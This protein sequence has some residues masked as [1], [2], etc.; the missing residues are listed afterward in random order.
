MEAYRSMQQRKFVEFVS[1]SRQVADY[2]QL[3]PLSTL[4]VL[5]DVFWVGDPQPDDAHEYAYTV[6]EELAFADADVG[7]VG[8]VFVPEL[9]VQL[10]EEV[11]LVLPHSII[12]IKNGVERSE[13]LYKD[14]VRH[15]LAH[16]AHSGTTEVAK[17]QICNSF[18]RPLSDFNNQDL[19]WGKRV[20]EASCETFKDLFWDKTGPKYA[21]NRTQLRLLPEWRSAWLDAV[22]PSRFFS[23]Q[24]NNPSNGGISAGLQEWR[25][26]PGRELVSPPYDLPL[27]KASNYKT[28]LLFADLPPGTHAFVWFQ[29]NRGGSY[30]K[31]W[32]GTFENSPFMDGPYA[33][34]P[35]VGA[36]EFDDDDNPWDP[37]PIWA[38]ADLSISANG[39]MNVTLGEGAIV[40]QEIDV[41][42]IWQESG[43]GLLHSNHQ[44]E[45]AEAVAPFLQIEV[46]VHDEDGNACLLLETYETDDDETPPMVD[47][48]TWRVDNVAGSDDD[49]FTSSQS[50]PNGF[51]I[52]EWNRDTVLGSVAHL[53]HVEAVEITDVDGNGI[54]KYRWLAGGEF[55]LEIHMSVAITAYYPYGYNNPDEDPNFIADPEGLQT[56]QGANLG[57]AKA[58]G[59]IGMPPV[60]AQGKMAAEIAPPGNRPRKPA[61]GAPAAEA[62]I[63][64]TINV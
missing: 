49:T 27:N 59:P 22:S 30:E 43:G 56:V 63:D 31:Q 18:G 39:Y 34:K 20:I 25:S 1:G 36:S 12:R 64:G 15:E 23:F 40:Y 44:D 16:V 6:N 32:H 28:G 5:L 33:P 10:G 61:V 52:P 55:S 60:F 26:Q 42:T 35:A 2:F 14:V 62:H 4:P 29:R 24:P 37:Y 21:N 57:V 11:R 58:S 8:V 7:S 53:E 48:W 19:P 50:G 41:G 45:A 3:F 47:G 17:Q 38:T 51:F 13:A 46:Q 54:G 9:D